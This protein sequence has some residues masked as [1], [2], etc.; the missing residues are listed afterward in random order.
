[1]EVREAMKRFDELLETYI[2]ARHLGGGRSELVHS[3]NPAHEEILFFRKLV[4]GW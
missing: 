3:F 2:A 4:G 1:M